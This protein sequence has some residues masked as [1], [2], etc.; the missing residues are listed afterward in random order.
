MIVRSRLSTALQ[1]SVPPFL[2]SAG[3]AIGMNHTKVPL[4][5]KLIAPK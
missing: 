1:S 4:F 2:L 3:D 5:D